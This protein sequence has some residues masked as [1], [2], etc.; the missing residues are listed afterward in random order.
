MGQIKVVSFDLDG[1]LI[2]DEFVDS[3]W[4]NGIPGLYAE[5]EGTSLDEA[6]RLVKNEYDK[7]GMERLEW[8]DVKYWLRRFGLNEDW[9]TLLNRFKS[10]IKLYPEVPTVLKKL[11][12]KG[13]ELVIITNSP[14][15]FLDIE[16]EGTGIRGYFKHIFSSTSDFNQVKKTTDFYAQISHILQVSPRQ[17]AHVGDNWTFDY[18]IP[19][20]IGIKSFYLDRKKQRTGEFVVRDLNE[21]A[22]RLK[23][24]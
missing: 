8:Y 9:K 16:L 23:P 11:R 7:V 24:P 2:D 21:F 20:R 6:Q 18:I 5:K 15:E 1:T 14:R 12:L 22:N 17:I 19:Q 3:V 4:Y 10:E 13:Y